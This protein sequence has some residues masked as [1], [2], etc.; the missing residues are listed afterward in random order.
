[1]G[2][3]S[4]SAAVV[5]HEYG[6]YVSQNPRTKKNTLPA[7]RRIIEFGTSLT[8][9]SLGVVSS[10]QPES[11]TLRA[12]SSC[13]YVALSDSVRRKHWT[14]ASKTV[15][16]ADIATWYTSTG[17][18]DTEYK[19]ILCRNVRVPS[20]A[21]FWRTN[22]FPTHLPTYLCFHFTSWGYK[23]RYGAWQGATWV[24]DTHTKLN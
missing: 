19:S 9:Q 7:R 21:F 1:M 22:Q 2:A 20:T 13:R 4:D 3:D 23:L 17:P 10:G 8:R 5:R 18:P 14:R 16:L 24:S 15:K 12:V 6:D 11:T